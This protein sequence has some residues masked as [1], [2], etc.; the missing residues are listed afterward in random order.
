MKKFALA[1]AAIA[2][3]ALSPAQAQRRPGPPPQRDEVIRLGST[4]LG[5][6]ADSDTIRVNSCRGDDRARVDSIRI[7][8][9][10]NDA[11]LNSVAV[12]YANGA[13]DR[14]TFR[15]VLRQGQ[16]TQWIDLRGRGRCITNIRVNG[17]ARSLLKPAQIDILGLNRWRSQLDLQDRREEM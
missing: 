14:I 17:S 2:T 16:T 10:R 13:Q 6:I 3:L 9:I 1:F 8:G 15:G 7:R 4:K 11:N 5:P 12:N